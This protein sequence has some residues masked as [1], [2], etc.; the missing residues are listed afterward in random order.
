MTKGQS[1]G[2]GEVKTNL[3]GD[4]GAFVLAAFPVMFPSEYFVNKR[5]PVSLTA[6]GL[7]SCG[8]GSGKAAIND[9]QHD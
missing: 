5:N 9:H 6:N 3:N 7:P 4:K 2:E 1:E 8:S